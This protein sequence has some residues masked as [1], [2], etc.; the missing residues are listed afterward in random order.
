LFQ[1]AERG[2]RCTAI[3][4][5]D[6]NDY[7]RACAG[8]EFTAKDYRA[9]SGSVRALECLLAAGPARTEPRHAARDPSRPSTTS[10]ERLRNTRSVCRKFIRAPRA[11]SKSFE[12]GWLFELFATACPRRRRR[13]TCRP[14]SETALMTAL[15]AKREALLASLAGTPKAAVARKSLPRRVR[16]PKSATS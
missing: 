2:R 3:N 7:L 15:V 9:W 11:C 5:S 16:K 8:T 12:K 4:S 1:Y 10:A 14:R 6:V 13:E